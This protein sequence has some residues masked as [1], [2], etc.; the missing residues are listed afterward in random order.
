[1]KF[2]PQEYTDMIVSYGMAGENASAAARIYAER[3]PGRAQYPSRR[4]IFRVVQQLR[5]TGCLVHNERASGAGA[6]MRLRVQDE[7]KI[8]RTFHE[9]PGISVR[10]MAQELGISRYA[11]HH[12]LRANDLPP[13]ELSA[14]ATTPT[15]ES[16]TTEQIIIKCEDNTWDER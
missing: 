4:V 12:T 6:P 11:V 8:L 7:E 2:T 9:N 5:E 1:M 3:F 13:T 10:R 16:I 14:C 15:E